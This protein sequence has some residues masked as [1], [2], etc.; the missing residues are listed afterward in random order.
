MHVKSDSDVTMSIEASTP[1]RSPR[2]PL[3]YVQSPSHSHNDLEKMSY[4]S[5]PFGSPAHHHFQYHCSPI[6]HSRESSTSRFSASLKNPKSFRKYNEA[7]EEEDEDDDED[8]R[9][10]GGQLMRFYVV[11]FVLS[12]VVLFSIF[13]LILW[14]A[15]LAYKPSVIVKSISFENFKIQAGMDATGV[16]TDMLTLNSTVRIFYKN[17]STFFGVHVTS[18]PPELHYFGLKVASGHIKRFYQLRKSERKVIAVVGG[19][20][21]P[22]YGGMPIFVSAK[23]HIDSMS[24]PLNLT[25][26]MRSRAYILGRLV[27]TKFYGRVLCEVTFRANHL[28]KPLNLT[29]SESCIYR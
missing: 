29:R 9:E 28:G 10:N 4:G 19:N 20:Q 22:L 27:K 7:G 14:A 18:T 25:F 11:C 26:V 21:V 16:P 13:S 5:S 1:P 3:Y 2:R 23:D 24:V 17:P 8:G 15:S 6:H 12:F